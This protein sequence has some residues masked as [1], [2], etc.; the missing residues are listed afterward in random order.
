MTRPLDPAT[1]ADV[2]A[3]QRLVLEYCRGIDRLDLEAVRRCY[4]PDAIDDHGTFRG[5]VDEY[6]AWVGRLLPRYDGTVHMV[7]NHLVEVAGDVARSEAY[8]VARHWSASGEDRL[9]LVIG[10]RYLD[11]V[12][13][14]D[15]DWRIAH[16]V[17]TTEWVEHVAPEQR[18]PIPPGIAVGRRDG[19][20]PLW[21]IAPELGGPV[22]PFG[23]VG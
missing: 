17:A 23:P 18:W 8:G 10:F 3:V 16:R 6:L 19:E 7:A 11:R 15:G 2:E 22:G 13:C 21:A 12:E 5:T 20:D 1:L 14:R 4:H 9:N